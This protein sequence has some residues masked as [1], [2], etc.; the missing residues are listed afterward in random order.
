MLLRLY[1]F[2]LRRRHAAQRA[3]LQY[4]ESELKD[5]AYNVART[6]TDLDGLNQSIRQIERRLAVHEEIKAR[7]LTA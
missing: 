4:Y 7:R 6:Q 3:A 5:A 2:W 1:L